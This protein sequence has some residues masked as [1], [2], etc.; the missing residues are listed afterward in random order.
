MFF[1]GFHLNSKT[2]DDAIHHIVIAQSA[3]VIEYTNCFS[4]KCPGYDT[5]Q[6]N[7]EFP[8]MLELWGMQNTRSLPSLPDP[9]WLGVIGSYL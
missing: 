2:K 6:S 5:K 4:A 3:E 7:G 9:F 1:S 8:V